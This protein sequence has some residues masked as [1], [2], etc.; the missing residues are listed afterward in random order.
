MGIQVLPVVARGV[1][2]GAEKAPGAMLLL[3]FVLSWM[4][5]TARQEQ[6]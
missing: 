6:K 2:G 5:L 3:R 1:E 4:F